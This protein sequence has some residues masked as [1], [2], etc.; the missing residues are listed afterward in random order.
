[1]QKKTKRRILVLLSVLIAI[2]LIAVGVVLYLLFHRVHGQYFDSAGVRIHYTVEGQGEPVILVHGLGANSDVNYRVTGVTHRLRKN[3]QVINFDCRGHGLSD[4]PHDPEKYKLELVE[5]VVRLM[6]HLKIPKAH[7][8][9]Y[10]MGGIIVTKLMVVHPDRVKSAVIGG[11]GIRP[12]DGT[13]KANPLGAPPDELVDKNEKKRSGVF[14]VA[15]ALIDYFRQSVERKINDK[16]ATRACSKSW[17]ALDISEADLRD[18]KVPALCITGSKD[19]L[20]AY[21]EAFHK[22]RPDLDYVVIPGGN[23]LTTLI[24]RE[25]RD[26]VE[27]FLLKNN[28]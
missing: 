14:A 13:D 5:D 8:V 11:Y 3:F 17:D 20:L 1:M 27:Q 9:G 23:H 25:F 4:K 15:S 19:G 24:C 10:S 6:D 16:E 7:V 12:K 18:C 22:I 2:P 28:K 26:T 21:A